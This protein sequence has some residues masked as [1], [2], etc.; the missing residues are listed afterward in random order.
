[1]LSDDSHRVLQLSDQHRVE[2]RSAL[3]AELRE[4]LGHGAV[5]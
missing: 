2:P 4:L 3:Y 1:M 5:R